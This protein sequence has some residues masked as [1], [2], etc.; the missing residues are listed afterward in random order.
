MFFAL[1]STGTDEDR[2]VAL[3]EQCLHAIDAMVQPEVDPHVEDVADLLVKDPGRQAK[4][5]DIGA[6]QPAGSIQ[7]LENRHLVTQ[8]PQIVSDRQGRASRA[9]QGDFLA[10]GFLGAFGQLRRYVVAVIRRDAF[11][12]AYRDRFVFDATATARGLARPVTDAPEDPRKDVGPAILH[13]RVGEPPLRDQAY[14]KRNVGMSRT[15][16]LA[17]DDFVKVVGIRD[18]SGFHRSETPDP[19]PPRLQSL[20]HNGP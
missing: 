19:V 8:W 3:V 16:P 13:V 9:D 7:R 20:Q 1:R 11:E 4:L 12:P 6:H 15:S 17:V 18:I 2:I 10:I 5:R 14:I